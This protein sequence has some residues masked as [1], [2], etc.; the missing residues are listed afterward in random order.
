MCGDVVI[1]QSRAVMTS[2]DAVFISSSSNRAFMSSS[3][4]N[5]RSIVPVDNEIKYRINIKS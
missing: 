4:K 3:Y 5:S 1:S 2:R